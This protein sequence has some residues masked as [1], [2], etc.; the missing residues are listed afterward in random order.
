MDLQARRTYHMV[1]NQIFNE[2][3]KKRKL[4]N[5]TQKLTTDRLTASVMKLI[6]DDALDIEQKV[7]AFRELLKQSQ[8][9]ENVLAD[10]DQWLDAVDG[11]GPGDP[12]VESYV[13]SITGAGSRDPKVRRFVEAITE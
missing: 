3:E 12:Q 6:H 10:Q 2:Q 7:A 13:K 9:A 1:A 4:D 11:R 8:R 5:D